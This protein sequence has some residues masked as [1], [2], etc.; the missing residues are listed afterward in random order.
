MQDYQ[1]CMRIDQLGQVEMN[2]LYNIGIL[3]IYLLQ[4]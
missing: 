2:R 4:F 1:V 3:D